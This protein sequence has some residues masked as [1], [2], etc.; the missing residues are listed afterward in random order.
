VLTV[1]T[2]HH[3]DIWGSGCI[4]VFLTLALFGQLHILAVL[5]L[6]KELLDTY[7]IQGWVGLRTGK[8][9]VERNKSCPYQD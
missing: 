6:G 1:L 4:D 9:E 7:R 8:D 5:L 2:L 3:E